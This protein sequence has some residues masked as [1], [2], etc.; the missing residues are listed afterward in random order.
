[1]CDLG[2]TIPYDRTGPGP[3]THSNLGPLCR[4]HHRLKTHGGWTLT[5][6]RPGEFHWLSPARLR[7]VTLPETYPQ[8]AARPSP[9]KS[10]YPGDPDNPP[11]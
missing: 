9:P 2:H 4:R 8:P 3:T 11:F 7:Y 1:M 10:T 6:P 5:Q